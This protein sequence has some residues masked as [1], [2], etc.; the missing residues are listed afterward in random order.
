M[1]ILF[2]YFPS[3]FTASSFCSKEKEARRKK[4]TFIKITLS[5][6]K[7]FLTG[8]FW[9]LRCMIFVRYNIRHALYCILRRKR[10]YR[11]Y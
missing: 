4:E 10:I 8:W 7:K 1:V 5:F 9:V 2:V 11:Y 6:V 3:L